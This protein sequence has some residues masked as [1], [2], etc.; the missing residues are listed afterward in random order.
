MKDNGFMK[1][2]NP[3]D[4]PLVRDLSVTR[5]KEGEESGNIF[6]RLH[7]KDNDWRWILSTAVSVS[8]DELGKVQQYIGFDIDITEEKEAKEKLQKALVETKAAKEQAE[9]HALEATTMREISEIVSSSLDLDKTL[10][11]ILDQAQRLVPF[12]T[13]SVQIMENNYLK[14]IGGRGWKNLERVIGYKWEIPGDNPNTVVLGT[15]KPYILGNVPERFSSSSNELTKEYAGK[16][17]LGI[18]LIFREE[19]IGIL[20]FLKY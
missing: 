11:A 20:T 2:V 14:I 6:F 18:P 7:T 15:K 9:A 3:G 10:E 17:W 12:D 13:A 19:I 16:S 4:A 5:D 1:Y 8:K